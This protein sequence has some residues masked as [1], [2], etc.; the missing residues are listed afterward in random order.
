MMLL[1]YTA[2]AS[3]AAGNV[4]VEPWGADS[5]RIRI[6]PPGSSIS[7][8]TLTALLPKPATAQN[9]WSHPDGS[10][11]TN[12]NLRVETLGSTRR[13]VRVSDDKLLLVGMPRGCPSAAAAATLAIDA[14]RSIL[15]LQTDGAIA[16]QTLVTINLQTPCAVQCSK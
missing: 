6:A 13:F 9:M 12:G 11:V 5:F 14:E 2:L 8:H 3:T 4:V 7:E 1:A 15:R 16:A 10:S